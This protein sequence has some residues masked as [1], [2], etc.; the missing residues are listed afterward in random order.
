[1][2]T[3]DV[4]TYGPPFGQ[5]NGLNLKYILPRTTLRTQ[6]NLVY[7]SQ[8]CEQSGHPDQHCRP[9]SALKSLVVLAVRYSYL[10]M[11][12]ASS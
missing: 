3:V 5:S 8:L 9:L 11:W 12:E 7:M 6:G 1:M 10:L 2:W 4:Y